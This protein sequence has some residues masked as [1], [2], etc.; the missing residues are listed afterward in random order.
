MGRRLVALA[1]ADRQLT[2]A[3]ALESPGHP[4]LG[5][6]AG[7]VAG[8]GPLGVPL[9]STLAAAAD[10]LIDFSQPTAVDAIVE[11]CRQAG[12]PLVLATTGLEP[13]QVERL[14]GTARLIPL[15]WSP[16]MSLAVNLTMKLCQVAGTALADKDADVE[17][18]ERHHRFKED[19]PS[20]TALKFGEIIS[21]AMGQTQHRH[22][23]SGRPGKRPHEEIGY[24]AIRV[25]D[26]PGEHTIVFGMLGETIELTVRATNRDCYALG[27]LAAAKF[28]A[29]K[30]AGLYGMNDVLGL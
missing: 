10:V 25:G 3:A 26:N 28:L 22:G 20:G 18:L 1:A 17:I 4:L 29:G 23:R 2:L 6:D 24:H 14:R 27:A 11:T 16:N 15:L 19:S 5:Q 12:L 8:S 30:P 21:R 7:T 9:A 13:A